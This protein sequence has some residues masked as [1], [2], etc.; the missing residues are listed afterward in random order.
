M[1]FENSQK[2]AAKFPNLKDISETC[3]TARSF[4]TKVMIK[5]IAHF[6]LWQN[7]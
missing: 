7:A 2:V 3:L 1:N 4:I 6:A 5:V